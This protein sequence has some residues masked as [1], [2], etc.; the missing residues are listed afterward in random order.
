MQ[1][2]TISYSSS[3]VYSSIILAGNTEVTIVDEDP[4]M[5]P[6]EFILNQNYPNPFN[7]VTNIEFLL[8]NDTKV[9]LTI[10]NVLGEKLFEV[11][12]QNMNAGLH[13]IQF[14]AKSLPSGIYFYELKTGN[15]NDVMK[16]TL[17][18]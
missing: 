10:Y 9:V 11:L 17:L 3:T 1:T 15:K 12:N 18:K 6:G 2:N 4:A 14:N 16:M 7:P 8:T 5:N 13:T